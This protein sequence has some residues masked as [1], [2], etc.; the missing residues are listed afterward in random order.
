MAR[1]T[2]SGVEIDLREAAGTITF[3]RAHSLLSVGAVAEVGR[4]SDGLLVGRVSDREAETA[5]VY[6]ADLSGTPA[7][8]SG[9]CTCDEP[10][11]CRHVVAVVMAAARGPVEADSDARRADDAARS[12]SWYPP[13]AEWQASLQALVT[14]S[15]WADDRFT[16]RV[17]PSTGLGLQFEVKV[18]PD[19]LAADEGAGLR[20][21]LRPAVLN[22][23]GSWV[24]SG[25]SWSSLPYS[26]TVV[27]PAGPHAAARCRTERARLVA[28]PF[29]PARLG[30]AG[31]AP[32]PGA[33][34]APG[35]AAAAGADP[36][37]LAAGAGRR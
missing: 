27:S 17:P 37:G 23:K 22:H 18:D 13:T 29:R 31:R 2:L 35:G 11:P 3:L 6:H 21:L 25:I 15:R 4:S 30:P 8:V 5:I 36:D 20:L 1:M 12:P 24:R 28:Q 14:R 33:G 16:D 34:A 26:R 19:P 10:T 7:R 32:A 9:S